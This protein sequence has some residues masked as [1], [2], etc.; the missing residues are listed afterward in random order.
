MANQN[1]NGLMDV[2]IAIVKKTSKIVTGIK[3]E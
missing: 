1:S 3:P 2:L